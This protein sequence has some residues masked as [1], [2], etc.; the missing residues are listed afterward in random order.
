MFRSAQQGKIRRWPT[1]L[2]PLRL[3]FHLYHYCIAVIQA[4]GSY[5]PIESAP[6][7]SVYLLSSVGTKASDPTKSLGLAAKISSELAHEDD[8]DCATDH[9]GDHVKWRPQQY[10]CYA[11]FQKS[12]G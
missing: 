2:P 12:R 1:F 3:D 8:G 11:S 6:R 4:Y 10:G 9:E 7:P 5:P